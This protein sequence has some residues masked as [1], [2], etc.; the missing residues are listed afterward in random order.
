MEYLDQVSRDIPDGILGE[1]CENE[2]VNAVIFHYQAQAGKAGIPMVLELNIPAD[3]GQVP[4]RD[5]CVIVGN[6][7]ENGIEACK[8]CREPFLTMKSRL[9]HGVLTITMDNAFSSVSRTPEGTFQ[10]SKPG[11]G[12]GLLSIRSVAEKYGGGCRFEDRDGTF[13]SS[14]YL[15]LEPGEQGDCQS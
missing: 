3:T 6:L 2:A 15:Y 8:S 1:F 13:Y 11:G 9:F 12:I 5:L 4:D 14:V 10:S 7:L